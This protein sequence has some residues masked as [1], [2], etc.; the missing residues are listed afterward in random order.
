MSIGA[1]PPAGLTAGAASLLCGAIAALSPEYL[2][3]TPEV[4][5]ASAGTLGLYGCW[6]L[7]RGARI[8]RYQR[9]LRRRRRWTI[10]SASR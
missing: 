9:N 2:M 1:R 8:V 4:G 3:I 7:A 10:R 5:Y 6:W